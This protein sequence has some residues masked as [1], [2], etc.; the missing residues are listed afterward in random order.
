MLLKN[1][2]GLATSKDP[3]PLGDKLNIKINHYYRLKINGSPMPWEKN[4]PKPLRDRWVS[5]SSTSGEIIKVVGKDKVFKNSYRCEYEK[6]P[7]VDI[8]ISCKF[9][10][11]LP[12][13]DQICRCLIM[14]SGCTCGAFQKE[15]KL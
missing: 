5:F 7:N 12:E 9:F 11:E 14:I 4:D 10:E 8:C 15:K 6:V 3:H 2:C 1:S 13:K